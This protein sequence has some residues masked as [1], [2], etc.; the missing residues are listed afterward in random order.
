MTKIC[1]LCKR[2]V[3]SPKK[4]G[5]TFGYDTY[6]VTEI[7]VHTDGEEM[8][9]KNHSIRYICDTCRF[10]HRANWLTDSTPTVAEDWVEE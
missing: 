5:R 1:V 7:Y 6:Q 2:D 8:T 10:Y 4:Y 9:T 3:M